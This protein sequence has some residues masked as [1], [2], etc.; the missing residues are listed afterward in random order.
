MSFLVQ[1]NRSKAAVEV[2]RVL[3]EYT[4][5]RFNPIGGFSARH[6]RDDILT[7]FPH[8]L[9]D[10]ARQLVTDFAKELKK[11]AIDRIRGIA[12]EKMGSET[13]FDIYILAGTTEVSPTDT[14]DQIVEKAGQTKRLLQL[15]GGVPEATGKKKTFHKNGG[16]SVNGVPTMLRDLN[17]KEEAIDLCARPCARHKSGIAK[18][19]VGGR[20]YTA[21]F[22]Y[23]RK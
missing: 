18:G 17:I 9:I 10:E 13:S 4:N 16:K 22:G 15:T 3:G 20:D 21:T 19:W 1:I 2:L 12:I 23:K 11:A 5:R 14:T 8:T 7:I 6:N